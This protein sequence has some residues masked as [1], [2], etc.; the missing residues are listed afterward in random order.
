MPDEDNSITKHYHGI[1]DY[2][3]D[4]NVIPDEDIS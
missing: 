3:K 1:V 4:R 2:S